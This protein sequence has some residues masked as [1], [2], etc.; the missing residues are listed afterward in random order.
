VLVAG[1]AVDGEEAPSHD[2]EDLGLALGLV[3][4]V[5]GEDV[6]DISQVTGE[7]ELHARCEWPVHLEVAAGGGKEK[8]DVVVYV[9]EVGKD[10]RENAY[11]RP[12]HREKQVC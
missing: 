11:Y 12:F 4:V 10:G 8:G 2:V 6:P 7:E 3:R 5:G 9:I 1:L